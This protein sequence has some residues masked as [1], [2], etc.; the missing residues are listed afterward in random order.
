[1]QWGWRPSSR[2]HDLSGAAVQ[3]SD[4][5]QNVC[6]GSAAGIREKYHLVTLCTY[7]HTHTHARTY[8]HT[9]VCVCVCV[10][11]CVRA[12]AWVILCLWMMM[13]VM[14]MMTMMMWSSIGTVPNP[15]GWCSKN[16]HPTCSASG[17]TRIIYILTR[18]Y[19]HTQA[20]TRTSINSYIYIYIY[21]YIWNPRKIPFTLVNLL[22]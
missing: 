17:Y 12:R 14:M 15:R 4:C 2:A 3:E 16:K 18:A 7:T 1:M 13:M 11:V 8:V 10:C 6:C 5:R 20:H 22:V 9:S 21:R 19:T